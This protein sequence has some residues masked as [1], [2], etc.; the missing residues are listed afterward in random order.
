VQEEEE[1]VEDEND[2]AVPYGD[3]PIC[4][5]SSVTKGQLFTLMF[6]FL[7]C[8]CC[9]EVDSVVH[10]KN[11]SRYD[12]VLI[13][14]LRISHSRLTQT[15]ILFGDYPPT[16]QLCGLSVSV[17]HILVEYSIFC[18]LPVISNTVLIIT[19]CVKVAKSTFLVKNKRTKWAELSRYYL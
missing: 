5:G 10:S 9:T 8:H 1:R 17:R 11:M 19:V 6:A 7:L 3:S 13:N 2:D 12:S 15:H 16:C 4:C 18:K 14:R